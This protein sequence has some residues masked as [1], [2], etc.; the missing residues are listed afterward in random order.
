MLR[1]SPALLKIKF[2]EMPC[3]VAAYLKR[4]ASRVALTVNAHVFLLDVLTV[5]TFH[6]KIV[7]A[8]WDWMDSEHGG[9]QVTVLRCSGGEKKTNILRTSKQNHFAESSRIYDDAQ[10]QKSISKSL[11]L[12]ASIPE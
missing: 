12:G 6:K 7:V 4:P 3:A 11:L 2:N 8:E 10:T 5:K 1:L 9:Q